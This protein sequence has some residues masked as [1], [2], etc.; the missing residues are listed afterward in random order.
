MKALRAVLGLLLL[1][2]L[3]GH[4]AGGSPAPVRLYLM[5]DADGVLYWTPDR[6]DP[7]LPK[8]VR[9]C[10]GRCATYNDD[11][12][13]GLLLYGFPAGRVGAFS[14][15]PS[16]PLRFRVEMDV[17]GAA[18]S[19]VGFYLGWGLGEVRSPAAAAVGPGVWE[20]TVSETGEVDATAT[21]LLGVHLRTETDPTDV[22]LRTGGRTWI[23]LPPGTPAAGV[24][25]LLAADTHRP[26]PGRYT[27]PGREL[28]FND[29]SWQV[30]ERGGDISRA[31]EFTFELERP[32]AGLFA[33]VETSQRPFTDDVLRGNPPDPAKLV[34]SPALRLHID[35]EYV[36][37][38]ANTGYDG[39][40]MA[41]VVAVDVPA[42]TVVV[43]TG[44]V[45]GPHLSQPFK[46]YVLRLYG[47][48]TLSSMTWRFYPNTGFA[49]AASAAVT[50]TCGAA[51]EALPVT[52]AV[53]TYTASFTSASVN[54]LVPPWTLRFGLPGQGDWVCGEPGMRNR[55]RFVPTQP[56]GQYLQVVPREDGNG[57]SYR[58]AALDMTVRY[59]H[60][61]P[62]PG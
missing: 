21:M 40:G 62:P 2:P 28:T 56:G 29:A 60:S 6:D 27:T 54:P 12:S 4:P 35:G 46:L 53:T 34:N 51:T 43:E 7:E 20:G 17:Q 33:W 3:T 19:E 8:L 5:A 52:A 61:A 24:P 1:V 25:A 15:G 26:E 16:A 14:W 11:G 47:E 13:R 36:E 57:L 48:R 49:P 37:T 18:P 55:M 10:P 50:R 32:V 30:D 45:F 59:T 38:G 9:S 22:V 39:R 42:S 31:H 23:E 41:S 44:P 58:D